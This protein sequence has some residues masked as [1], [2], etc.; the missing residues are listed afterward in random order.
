M[1]QLSFWNVQLCYVAKTNYTVEK[2]TLLF[3]SGTV[4]QS[5][6]ITVLFR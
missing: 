2:K 6:M 4:L 3:F 5:L 1:I